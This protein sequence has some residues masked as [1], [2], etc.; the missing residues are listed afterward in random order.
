MLRS[1]CLCAIKTLV[2]TC[3]PGCRLQGPALPGP[4][5]LPRRLTE[6]AVR[7]AA[8]LPEREEADSQPSGQAS[9]CLPSH[10]LCGSC[11]FVPSLKTRYTRPLPTSRMDG[12][13]RPPPPSKPPLRK[14]RRTGTPLPTLWRPRRCLPASQRSLEP[15]E[16]LT[17]LNLVLNV[18]ASTS[19][20]TLRLFPLLSRLSLLPLA[21]V[22]I[23]P[24]FNTPS[25]HTSMHVKVELPLLPNP[26]LHVRREMYGKLLH[27]AVN[28]S[29]FSAHSKV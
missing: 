14:L 28:S 9:D 18:V 21:C 26:R 25:V 13:S 17:P 24:C 3:R 1:K 20:S 2:L 16:N 8:V 29:T 6:P 23:I 5:R 12:N 19:T 15:R 4:R 22:Y 10:F 7:C 11:S 27:L